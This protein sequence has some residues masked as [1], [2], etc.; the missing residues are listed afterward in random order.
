MAEKKKK[1]R[2]KEYN[3]A[4]PQK[5]PELP[6]ERKPAPPRKTSHGIRCICGSDRVRVINT[7]SRAYP[8]YMAQ[9]I[10]RRKR[11]CQCMACGRVWWM[12]TKLTEVVIS[13]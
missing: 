8:P 2:S 12:Q 4:K 1:N 6:P 5:T 13:T 10:V 11:Q 3:E 9:R 7:R